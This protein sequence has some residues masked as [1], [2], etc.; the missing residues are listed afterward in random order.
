M[1][2]LTPY[3]Y[4]LPKAILAAIIIVAVSHLIKIQPIIHAFNSDKHE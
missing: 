4:Y 2:Y 3:L 1:V